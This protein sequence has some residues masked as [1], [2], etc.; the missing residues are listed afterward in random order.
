MG[1]LFHWIGRTNDA[2]AFFNKS[3]QKREMN[4]GESSNEV[5]EVY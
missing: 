1:I 5:A 2:I 3:H 4:H